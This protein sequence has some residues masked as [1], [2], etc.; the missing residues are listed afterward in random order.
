VEI[1]DHYEVAEKREGEARIDVHVSDIQIINSCTKSSRR[2]K[3]L[4]PVSVTPLHRSDRLKRKSCDFEFDSSS[5]Q[6]F[7]SCFLESHSF[8]FFLDI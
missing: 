7:S 5:P 3:K 8:N 6:G 2:V 1:E 4:K